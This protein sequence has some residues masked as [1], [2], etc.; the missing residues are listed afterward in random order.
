M[1]STQRM[2]WV[3]ALRL[4]AGLSMVGLHATADPAGQPWP[5]YETT[6]R[7]GPIVVRSILD[8]ARTELFIIISVFLLVLALDR[9]PR[10]YGTVISEQS[11]RLLIPFLF[12][13]IFYAFYGLIKA[14]QFWLPAK[15]RRFCFQPCKLARVYSARRREVS[16]ALHPNIIWHPA[17]FSAFCFGSEISN[18]RYNCTI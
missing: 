4:I 17:V 10:G 9:R 11:R 18:S 1:S 3:D 14:A 7:I 13:T 12:W 2:T 15:C 8:M 6:E 5:N 16:H